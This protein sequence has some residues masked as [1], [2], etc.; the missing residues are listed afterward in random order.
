MLEVCKYKEDLVQ[1]QQCLEKLVVQDLLK[2]EK[3]KIKGVI[4]ID[5]ILFVEIVVIMLGIVVE[6]LLFNQVLVFLGIVLVV[7]VGVYGLVGVIVK[8]DDLG[9]WLVEK[10][11]VLM[12]VLGK[13]LLIIVFW[14]MKV[15]LIVGM[16]VMF[17][18]GGG[19]V[20]YG[21]VLL[22]YVIEYFVGQ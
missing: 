19:I 20:V 1:S 17:F 5:F 7:I 13:G 9:Y 14:L 6:V 21:I 22:Y 10:F 3:D 18:V 11:S 16:L 8:I 15:L 4:C 2:F 12:Q